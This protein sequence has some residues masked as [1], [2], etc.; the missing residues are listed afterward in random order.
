MVQEG[1][2]VLLF[3]QSKETK[4]DLRAI[5]GDLLEEFKNKSVNGSIQLHFSQGF[6]AKI[7]STRVD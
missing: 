7:H 5:F 1:N 3:Y 2:A 4:K 6:L